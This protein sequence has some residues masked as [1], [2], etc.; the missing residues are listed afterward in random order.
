PAPAIAWLLAIKVLE[1]VAIPPALLEKPPPR[2]VP[3]TPPTVLAPLPGAPP[4][5]PCAAFSRMAQWLTVMVPMRLMMAPPSPRPP[6]PPVAAAAGRAAAPTGGGVGAEREVVD[7]RRGGHK[8]GGRGRGRD[9]AAEA[10]AGG[11]AAAAVPPL[12]AVAAVR[13]VAGELAVADDETR[14]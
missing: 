10:E 1:T 7:L 14:T 8:R 4:A 12:A 9:G 3:P 6:G 13:F 5:P 11:S 2:A